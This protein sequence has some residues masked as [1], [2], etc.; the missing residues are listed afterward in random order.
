MKTSTKKSLA[1]AAIFL[2]IFTVTLAATGD[3]V[4]AMLSGIVPLL[5]GG[6]END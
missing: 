2:F 5:I 3:K 1:R 6:Y 4:F